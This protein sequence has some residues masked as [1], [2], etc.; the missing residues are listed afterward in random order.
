[1]RTGRLHRD[2]RTSQPEFVSYSHRDEVTGVGDMQLE[3][4]GGAG[5]RLGSPQLLHPSVA[6]NTRVHADRAGIPRRIVAGS[7][8]CLGAAL[9]EYPLLRVNQH[10][11]RWRIIEE[12]GIKPFGLRSYAVGG[13]CPSLPGPWETGN[14]FVSG[15][16][17]TPEFIDIF[18]PGETAGK[19]DNRDRV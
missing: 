19:A 16:Q 7:F 12:S 8:Q 13:R 10:R 4:L 6:T 11:F 17:M 2:S 18:S 5:H 3:S 9:Q 1:R 15:Q 14:Q